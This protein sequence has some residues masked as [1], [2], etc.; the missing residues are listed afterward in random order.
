[1]DLA[2][3]WMKNWEDEGIGWMDYVLPS[4]GKTHETSENVAWHTE[5]LLGFGDSSC[6]KTSAEEFC[7][8]ILLQSAVSGILRRFR[9]QFRVQMRAC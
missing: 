6:I 4:E 5:K 8:T 7:P 9:G 1:M 2:T 3:F